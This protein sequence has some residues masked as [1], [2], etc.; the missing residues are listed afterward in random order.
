MTLNFR[1]VLAGLVVD[2]VGVIIASAIFVTIFVS[3]MSAK[4]AT[5]EEIRAL[6]SNPFESSTLTFILLSIGVLFDGVA[7]YVTAH[8]AGYLEYWH[9]LAML[10]LLI[11]IQVAMSSGGPSVPGMVYAVSYIGGG[12]AAFYGAWLVKNKRTSGS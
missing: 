11:I 8:R 12:A 10:G 6:L 1:A 7:G 9:V 2:L 4:G 5:D 3:N